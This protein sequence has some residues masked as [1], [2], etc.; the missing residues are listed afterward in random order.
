[1]MNSVSC[2][3]Y[4]IKVPE[5][6]PPEAAP[7][8]SSGSLIACLFTTHDLL[9]KGVWTVIG[10][11]PPQ[12]PSDQLPYEDRRSS[13]WIGAR[14]HGSGIVRR[15]LNAYYRL[16]PWDDWADPKYLDALLIDPSKRPKD[17]IYIKTQEA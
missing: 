2:A 5:T 4:N 11:A 14:M 16:E 3:L 10:H 7:L 12:I 13:G 8:P 1:M 9:R 17:L 6:C 15:F